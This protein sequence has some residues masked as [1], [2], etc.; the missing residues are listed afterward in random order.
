[1][2]LWLQ[3]SLDKGLFFGRFSLNM[4]GFIIK[5]GITATVGNYKRDLSESRAADPRQSASRVPL[6]EQK[7]TVLVL[8]CHVCRSLKFRDVS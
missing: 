1:M 4:G 5:V 6:T 8:N 7:G 2:G 3:N